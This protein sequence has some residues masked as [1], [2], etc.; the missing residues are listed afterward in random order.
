[1][2][3]QR[4]VKGVIQMERNND[5]RKEFEVGSVLEEN[6]KKQKGRS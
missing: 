5:I 2:K 4:N 3:F 6:Y 1:M